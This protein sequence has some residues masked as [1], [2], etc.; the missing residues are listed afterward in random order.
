MPPRPRSIIGA[1]SR[2]LST[3][4]AA[5][6]TATLVRQREARPERRASHYRPRTIPICELH[7]ADP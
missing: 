2:W 5:Q 1:A 6:L 7:T 3:V 4:G